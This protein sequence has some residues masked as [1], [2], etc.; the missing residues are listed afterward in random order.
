MNSK[1]VKKPKQKQY[2]LAKT[3][4]KFLMR[5]NS[6][7]K[8][9]K[10][11][12]ALFDAQEYSCHNE[13]TQIA[14]SEK[15]TF[16][17]SWINIM[18]KCCNAIDVIMKNPSRFIK[19][20]RQV[21]PIALAKHITS[22]SV[23]HLASHTQYI[24]S[25]DD[26][27]NVTPDKILSLS[28]ED[29]FAI[30]E[31]RF[32]YTLI[33]KL[34]LFIE[35]RYQYVSKFTDTNK[36]DVLQTKTSFKIDGIA[37]EVESKIKMITNSEDE[38]NKAKTKQYVERIASL[39]KR[40]GFYIN[41]PFVQSLGSDIKTVK[42]PIMQTNMIRKNAYYRACYN[43]WKFIDTY[44]KLGVKYTVKQQNIDID[45][46][47]R[48]ELFAL[49]LAACLS[50]QT[51]SVDEERF[52]PAKTKKKVYIPR[53][54]K[55]IDDVIFDDTKFKECLLEKEI[56][57]VEDAQ[58]AMKD[59]E[60][61]RKQ[62]EKEE[63]A[64]ILKERK[65]QEAEARRLAA[66]DRKKKENEIR[67]ERLRLQKEK[68]KLAL[69]EKKRK[70]KEEQARKKAL[71]LAKKKEIERLRKEYSLLAK[72]RAIVKQKAT[73]AKNYEIEQARKEEAKQKELLN[74][75]QVEET[76]VNNDVKID[77]EQVKPTGI[78]NVKQVDHIVNIESLNLNHNKDDEN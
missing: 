67:R 16:D 71:E 37:Y 8:T 46:K 69:A 48:K 52:N 34:V 64:R 9:D 12:N 51:N 35:K 73:I 59:A 18:E 72:T 15:K 39:R 74:H 57:Y 13:F 55:I 2:S 49:N 45:E 7:A 68:A 42:S 32:V 77:K 4:K 11:F 17:E 70:Q 21:T 47:Y 75:Q 22:E 5:M 10:G 6:L 65:L 24:R 30:Y 25:V 29:E 31:N 38:V 53:T 66:L 76:N 33:K 19:E 60:R 62:K 40:V 41:S 20:V 26:K 27:G 63:Q 61:I 58:K 28:T 14:R 43:A 56:V 23:S 3:Q 36:Y 78:I 1:K 54:K 50:L 44:N